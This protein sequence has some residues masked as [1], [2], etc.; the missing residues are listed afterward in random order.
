VYKKG[1][2]PH[3][4][5]IDKSNRDDRTFSRTDFAFDSATNNTSAQPARSSNKSGTTTP[6][7]LCASSLIATH[8][9]RVQ[10]K[11]AAAQTP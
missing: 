9:R 2:E 10:G 3:V 8:V 1:I 6:T 4:P 7:M 5:V 11:T